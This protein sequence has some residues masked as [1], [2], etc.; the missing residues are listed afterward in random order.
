MENQS[1]PNSIHMLD[2]RSIP[3]QRHQCLV[4]VLDGGQLSIWKLNHLSEDTD[5]KKEG[6]KKGKEQDMEVSFSS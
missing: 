4:G 2:L 3:T 1:T 6:G 5:R